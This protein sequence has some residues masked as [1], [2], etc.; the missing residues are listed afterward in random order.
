VLSAENVSF[1]YAFKKNIP[2]RVRVLDAVSFD[3]HKGETVG[4]VGRNG[5]G[6]STL[7]RLLAGVFRPSAGEVRTPKNLRCSLLSLGVG[8]LNDLSGTDNVT[9]SLM[10]QGFN[11]SEIKSVLPQIREF[12]ELAGA[13]E[14]RVKTYSSG[15][16]SRLTFST[17]LF[18]NA[19]ILLIDE[20]LAVGDGRFKQKASEAL[21]EKISGQQTVVLVSHSEG[22]IAK[23]CDRVI[24]MEQGRVVLLGDTTDV[25]EQYRYSY[26]N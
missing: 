4:V 9:I 21:R 14:D 10:L 20:V 1:D 16:R 17:A 15:M 19:D 23:L 18:A 26:Q 8:F 3:L 25:L 11:E 12:S 13:F 5:A 22:A 6:K 7:L 24:W 2:E